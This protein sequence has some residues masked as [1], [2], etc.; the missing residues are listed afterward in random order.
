MPYLVYKE[1]LL[2]PE[3]AGVLQRFGSQYLEEQAS[4]PRIVWVPKGE[5]N[6]GP[7][8]GDYP[9]SIFKE[10]TPAAPVLLPGADAN[11]AVKYIGKVAGVRVAQE[12]MGA[13]R[14]EAVV[15]TGLDVSVRLAVDANGVVTST[16]TSLAATVNGSAAAS[17]LTAY[18]QGTGAGLAKSSPRVK[19]R[20]IATRV[21]LVELHLFADD[22][23]AMT[24]RP[25]G[26]IN[27]LRYALWRAARGSLRIEDAQWSDDPVSQK[28]WTD[29]C[30]HRV[31]R[32]D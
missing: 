20:S 12:F 15:V 1:M 6:E 3:L 11:G 14:S 16:A 18:A 10:I 5:K 32:H 2:A 27:Q 4:A 9:V 17:L 28:G 19:L 23:D 8:V 31:M 25:G 29:L 7:E 30:S 21:A 22:H 26:L 24:K 13:G